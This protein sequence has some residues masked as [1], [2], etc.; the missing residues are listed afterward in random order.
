M[1]DFLQSLGLGG[2]A[3]KP[4]NPMEALAGQG[5][6]SV[7]PADPLMPLPDAAPPGQGMEPDIT[8]VGDGWKPK[9]ATFLSKIA[10]GYLLSRG[11]KPMNHIMREQ[12]NVAEAMRGYGQDPRA[13]LRRLMQIPGQ[14]QEA[15]AA[16]NMLSD[17]E[18]ADIVAKRQ[19]DVASMKYMGR[20]GGMLNSISNS[21]DPAGQY[22]RMLPNIK[23][24]AD[25]YGLDTASLPDKYDEEAIK[26]YV[27]GNVDVDD[28]LRIDQ[29]QDYRDRR[30]G[31]MDRTIDQREEY[32][33]ASIAQRDRAEAGRNNRA[34]TSEAG[35][36]NRSMQAKPEPRYVKTPNG[37]MELSPSGNL[38]KI[39]DQI[40]QKQQNGQWKRVK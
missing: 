26:T 24:Y 9:K 35:R 1:A 11:Q 4:V 2:P 18:R 28:Q 31:Q 21:K 25:R 14:Q 32:Q 15:L 12:R 38:G 3:P 23:N 16:Y 33:D 40:W 7:A 17:N 13:A 37:S 5:P 6:A 10:D 22:E 8:V 29:M 30:L 36:N 20:L 39:G 34:A 27:M 19:E